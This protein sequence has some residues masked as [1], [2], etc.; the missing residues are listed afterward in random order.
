MLSGRPQNATN[1][2]PR[3]GFVYQLNQRTVLRGG[4][5]KYYGEMVQRLSA[6]A[7]TVACGGI[8][9]GRP[10]FAANPLNGPTPTYDEAIGGIVRRPSRR[11]TFAAWKASGYA[12]NAPCLFRGT[13]N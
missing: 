1:I 12:G 3:L 2:Q 9:D 11:A 4:A 10:D 5:G 6:A 8:N 13:A 7:K